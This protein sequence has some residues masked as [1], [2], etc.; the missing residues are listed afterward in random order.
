MQVKVTKRTKALA[1]AFH[2]MSAMKLDMINVC[3]E[4]YH[5]SPAFMMPKDNSHSSQLLRHT[6]SLMKLEA[7]H[8][9]LGM[10]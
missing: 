7:C 2:E 9:C 3:Y 10:H 6:C 1:L 5:E 4:S 8:E